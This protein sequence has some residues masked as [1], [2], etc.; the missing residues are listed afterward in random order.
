MESYDVY[1]G[2]VAG[3]VDRLEELRVVKELER[4]RV[5][6]ITPYVYLVV[7]GGT[8]EGISMDDYRYVVVWVGGRPVGMIVCKVQDS[9]KLLKKEELEEFV[10]N[11]KKGE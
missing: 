9:L 1:D 7:Y 8:E 11:Y 2:G 10:R 4:V 5:Y 3:L 6:E